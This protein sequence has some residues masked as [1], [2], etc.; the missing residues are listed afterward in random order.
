MFGARGSKGRDGATRWLS[1]AIVTPFNMFVFPF[2]CYAPL[3][4]T[5]GYITLKSGHVP[6][7]R[8][9]GFYGVWLL[10]VTDFVV[11]QSSHTKRV[12]V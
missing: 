11:W 4:T 10:A 3:L 2:L 5:A 8:K 7:I 12:G 6:D 1:G 9:L